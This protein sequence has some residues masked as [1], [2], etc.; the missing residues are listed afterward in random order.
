VATAIIDAMARSRLVLAAVAGPHGDA[1]LRA[2]AA[3]KTITTTT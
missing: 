2:S 3:K 1:S